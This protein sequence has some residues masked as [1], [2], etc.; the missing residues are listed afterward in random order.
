MSEIQFTDDQVREEMNRAGNGGRDF[1]AA[2]DRLI[3]Q[4]REAE[5]NLAKLT[6]VATE[7]EDAWMIEPSAEDILTEAKNFSLKPEDAR[8]SLRAKLRADAK[9]LA[10]FSADAAEEISAARAEAE[11][12]REKFE[13]LLAETEGQLDAVTNGFVAVGNLRQKIAV[14]KTLILS[15]ADKNQIANRALDYFCDMRTGYSSPAVVSGF[16]NLC[17]DL[18]RREALSAHVKVRLDDLQNQAAHLVNSIKAQAE[19]SGMDLKKVFALLAAERTE[20]LFKT[21]E[22]FAGLI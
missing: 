15:G 22:Y 18:I 12:A 20:P 9:R 4:H 17:D 5:R 19:Q 1:F 10:A 14:L 16:Q 13:M 7:T 21:P 6:P 11:A 2:R 3:Q 8:E